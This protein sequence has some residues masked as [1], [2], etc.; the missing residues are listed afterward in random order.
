MVDQSK[1]TSGGQGVS[2]THVIQIDEAVITSMLSRI[3]RTVRIAVAAELSEIMS[4]LR[5]TKDTVAPPGSARAFTP[6]T[7]SAKTPR[8]SPFPQPQRRQFVIFPTR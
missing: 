1:P 5:G 3:E 7:L 6:R 8:T 2:V 4:K